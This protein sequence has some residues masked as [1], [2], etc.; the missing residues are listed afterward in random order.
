SSVCEVN[1]L[2]VLPRSRKRDDQRQMPCRSI[3]QDHY[4]PVKQLEF[5]C[6]E[7]VPRQNR[8]GYSEQNETI[9]DRADALKH[10]YASRFS[11]AFPRTPSRS[12]VVARTLT[13]C[14]QSLIGT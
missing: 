13:K 1:P 11:K 5:S 7:I 14:G 4:L 2:G 8:I 9:N 12:V 10:E 6:C 3:S